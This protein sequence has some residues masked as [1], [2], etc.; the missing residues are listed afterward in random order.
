MFGHGKLLDAIEARLETLLK[1]YTW[2]LTW[3]IKALEERAQDLQTW[4]EKL[5]AKNTILRR[6]RRRLRRLLD[7]KGIPWVRETPGVE[8][9]PST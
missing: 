2:D 4:N 7:E 8:P 5:R 3:R 9:P 1:R 6:D